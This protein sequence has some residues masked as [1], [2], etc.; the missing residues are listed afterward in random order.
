MIYKNKLKRIYA[1]I[2]ALAALITL[3]IPAY[4][5]MAP[6]I[7]GGGDMGVP[8]YAGGRSG[9]PFDPE[10]GIVSDDGNGTPGDPEN[11]IIDGGI[12]GSEGVDTTSAASGGMTTDGGMSDDTADGSMVPESTSGTGTTGTTPS[13]SGDASSTTTAV[14]NGNEVSSGTNNVWGIIIT[15]LIIAAIVLLIFA[16]IPKKH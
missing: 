10:N 13:T 14:T 9:E 4:A 7:A 3:I 8:R 11:G 6:G 12:G 2:F 1:V 5:T 15:I 16:F